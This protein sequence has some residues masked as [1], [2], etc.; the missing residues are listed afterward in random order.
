MFTRR[1]NSKRNIDNLC[2]SYSLHIP[3]YYITR[4]SQLSFFRTHSPCT[5]KVR[6]G[7]LPPR[8]EE[9]SRSRATTP[10]PVTKDQSSCDGD[11]NAPR[12]CQD[13]FHEKSQDMLADSA[14]SPPHLSSCQLSPRSDTSS[15]LPF[16]SFCPSSMANS[17][18]PT[19]P[20]SDLEMDQRPSSSL[21]P[22][23]FSMSPPDL[24]SPPLSTTSHHSDSCHSPF[25]SLPL[26]SQS[27]NICSCSS[28]EDQQYMHPFSSQTNEQSN[29]TKEQSNRTNVTE[30][31]TIIQLSTEA[32]KEEF[33][34]SH[35]CVCR[36]VSQTKQ[37]NN[38]VLKFSPSSLLASF[39]G[40]NNN[41]NQPNLVELE[42]SYNENIKESLMT[43]SIE[44]LITAAE[45]AGEVEEDSRDARVDRLKASHASPLPADI[46]TLESLSQVL[47]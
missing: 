10:F 4:L 41:N 25:S 6:R 7:Q 37:Q 12:V 21:S 34:S 2:L 30:S 16:S 38:Q 26:P 17:S 9:T 47:L 14:T 19:P 28:S 24:L 20:A 39:N 29:Q 15:F 42:S 43:K 31:G 8:R 3:Q 45:G 23:Y 35:P 1:Q 5:M 18:L 13:D 33:T 36:Q 11:T 40:Q 44:P 22:S 46:P 32:V 27:S